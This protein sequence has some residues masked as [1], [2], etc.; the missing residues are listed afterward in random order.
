MTENAQKLAQAAKPK[1]ISRTIFKWLWASYLQR[2]IGLLVV[3]I[4]LKVID[5]LTFKVLSYIERPIFLIVPS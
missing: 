2:H 5:S 3:A 4:A 1:R